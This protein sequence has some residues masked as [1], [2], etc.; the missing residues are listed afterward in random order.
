ML[1]IIKQIDK[2]YDHIQTGNFFVLIFNLFIKLFQFI[3]LILPFTIFYIIVFSPNLTIISS[4]FEKSNDSEIIKMIN[5]IKLLKLGGI[6]NILKTLPISIFLTFYLF[7]SGLMGF[8]LIKRTKLNFAD[9]SKSDYIVMKILAT[10]V[11]IIGEYFGFLIGLTL[12]I[13]LFFLKLFSY[14]K[15][16]ISNEILFESI[17]D[18]LSYSFVFLFPLIG[19]VIL[20]ISRFVYEQIQAL[21]FSH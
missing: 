15:I 20:F 2:L 13:F 16:K 8:N 17:H 21:T 7:F 11:K 4:E 14:L 3:A 5:S 18:H 1:R 6:I 19:I 9:F 10:F 12:P